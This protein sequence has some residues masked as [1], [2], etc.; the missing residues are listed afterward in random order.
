MLRS[1]PV[2][3]R[4]TPFHRG[5]WEVTFADLFHDAVRDRLIRKRRKKRR[6][7]FGA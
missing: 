6:L 5:F 4:E 1:Y 7:R 3:G 2:S